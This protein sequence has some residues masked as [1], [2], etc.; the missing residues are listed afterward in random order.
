MTAPL[1]SDLC[2]TGVGCD[3]RHLAVFFRR[4]AVFLGERTVEAGVVGKTVHLACLRDVFARDDPRPAGLEAA[5][6]DV[7]MNGKTGYFFKQMREIILT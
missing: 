6:G 2:L 1:H 7:L 4:H 5:P 3:A